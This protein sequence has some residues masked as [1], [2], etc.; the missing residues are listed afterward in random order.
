MSFRRFIMKSARQHPPAIDQQLSIALDCSKLQGIVPVE[1]GEAIAL[2][3]G[4]L[5]EAAGIVVREN[6]ND[7]L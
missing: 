4:L 3:A 1:R 7:R 2:L 6:G 5:M